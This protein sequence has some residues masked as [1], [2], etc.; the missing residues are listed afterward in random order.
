MKKTF[1]TILLIIAIIVSIIVIKYLDYKDEISQIKEY[2]LQFENYL[3]KDIFGTE[4]ASIINKA[5]DINEQNVIK[6]NEN[7]KY[8]QND[9]SINIEIKITDLE[10]DTIYAMETLYNG[11]MAEFVQYYNSIYFK[12]SD[13]KYNNNGKICYILFEQ[14]TN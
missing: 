2:N 4:I 1:I 12:S 9:D 13:V 10:E 6:K 5:V 11:G 14:V 7:G 8:I 3:E